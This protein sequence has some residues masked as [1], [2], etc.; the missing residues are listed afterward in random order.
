MSET[1]WKT[2]SVAYAR[3]LKGLN[4]ARA[5]PAEELKL[6]QVFLERQRFA[7]QEEQVHFEEALEALR[8]EKQA[9][10][11]EKVANQNAAQVGEA[12]CGRR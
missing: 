7:T 11:A 5:E 12:P 1:S 8:L 9:F 4:I 10:Q 3:D 2:N 6:H